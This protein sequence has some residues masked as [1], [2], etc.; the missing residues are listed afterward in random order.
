[1]KD[2]GDRSDV[3]RIAIQPYRGALIASIQVDLDE[4]VL[5]Q[6]Q[7]D[8]LECVRSSDADVAIIDL[9][10]VGVIDGED[11]TALRRVIEMTALMGT[12]SILCGMQPG[13]AASLVDLDVSLV[14]LQI[15]RSLD[16]ALAQVAA[17]DTQ[18][19]PIVESEDP[20]DLED[21]EIVHGLERDEA[22]DPG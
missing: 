20:Q 7:S 12:K 8:L 2:L 3:A 22:L 13:V 9:S 5:R 11:F 18:E 4:R 6:F 14:G 16:S 15:S 21:Q 1:M 17:A 10:G 19:E